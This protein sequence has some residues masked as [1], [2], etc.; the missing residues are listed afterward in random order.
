MPIEHF[1]Q[2]AGDTV[3][4][5]GDAG[6]APE[7]TIDLG[8]LAN[9]I[10]SSLLDHLGE[11]GTAIWTNLA[12][13]L[14]T[15]GNAIW[16]DLGQ[17]MY[18]LM[19]GLL[20]TLWNATLLPIPHTTTDEFGPV[21]AMLPGTGALAAAGITLAL[22]LLG[23]RTILHGT[24]G[25]SLLADYLLGR[26]IVWVAVLSMLPWMI[27]H[28]IDAEQSLARSVAIGDLG[29]ILP[30][31][32]APN[33]LAMFLMIVMGLRLWLKLASNVV[34]VAVAIVWSPVAA[35]CG[36]IPETQHIASLWLHEFFGR[37]AGAVLATIA[38]GVGLALAL[39][40]AGGHNGDFA[41]FGA[42]GAFVA[43]YDLVDWLAKTPG[44]SVGGVLGGMARTGAALAAFAPVFGNGAA[45]GAGGAAA[46][47]STSSS[48]APAL[49]AASSL[50]TFY[51][52]D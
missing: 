19:R 10:W 52:F 8:G 39:T 17:W 43:A 31:E 46:A 14:P 2:T 35:V 47:G 45:L 18:G 5:G 48:S 28:A 38:T 12:P 23:V 3:T 27:S 30:E 22:A 32:V 24:T 13:Q 16:T 6:G 4:T 42:A 41:I 37:L 29:G 34:H 33:P 1:L 7:I 21:Q 11:L 26:F 51:S 25:H 50:A 40:N 49:P 20:L 36:L 15:I 9:A 44:S